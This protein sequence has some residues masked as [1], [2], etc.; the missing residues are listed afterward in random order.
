VCAVSTSRPY[1]HGD[2]PAALL[3]AA[4]RLL[5]ED[6]AFS[7]RAVAR[8]AGV[9]PNA[10]YRHYADK[11]ALLAALATDGFAR[12]ADRLDAAAELTDMAEQYV[13]FAL[14]HPRLF[15]LM[16]GR[17]TANAAAARPGEIRARGPADPVLQVGAWAMVHGLAVL[18]L[19]G[20]LTC[21]DPAQLVRT[22]VAAALTPAIPAGD[23]L[24]R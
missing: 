12:L 13:A 2:L 20:K 11:E 17:P 14:E 6:E 1:H 3:D 16:Y 24:D 8:R 19:D 18:L 23:L 9:S 5:E 22:T 15:R 4:L 21:A 7:L 10:P